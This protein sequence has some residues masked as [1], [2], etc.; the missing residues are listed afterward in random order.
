MVAK[1]HLERTNVSFRSSCVPFPKFLEIPTI[2]RVSKISKVDYCRKIHRCNV[3]RVHNIESFRIYEHESRG[4]Y[5][6]SKFLELLEISKVS[7]IFAVIEDYCRNSN[8]YPYNFPYVYPFN[9]ACC[10]LF[11]SYTY[12]SLPQWKFDTERLSLPNC[13]NERFS[14]LHVAIAKISFIDRYLDRCLRI[15][16]SFEARYKEI[17]SFSFPKSL[18]VQ[19]AKDRKPF[20][21]YE[22]FPA[23]RGTNVN[24]AYFVR[25]R[26]S[27]AR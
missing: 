4:T 9:T 20:R 14:F 17:R 3:T 24:R 22:Y 18:H 7:P 26:F 12:I 11:L 21:C 2:S 10:S 6:F 1:C 27:R 13:S 5:Y 15:S 8:I 19:L 25:R 23:T 16:N